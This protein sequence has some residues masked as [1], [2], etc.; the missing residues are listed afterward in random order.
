MPVAFLLDENQR[1]LA[2]RYILQH[3]ARG[4]DNLDVVRIGDAA[5]LPL[6]SDDPDIL[7]W[8]ERENR[9]LISV[10]RRT[11]ASHLANHIAQ[12]RRCPG[13]FQVRDVPFQQ[14]ISFLACVA[15][16]SEPGEWENRITYIP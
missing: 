15:Y 7:V 5:D 4:I 14:V 12:G 9:I 10:D 13:I 3:N 6:G 8:A 1:G 11:L 2:W 16:A